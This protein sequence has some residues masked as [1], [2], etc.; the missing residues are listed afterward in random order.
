MGAVG[1][2]LDTK[3]RVAR[4]RPEEVSRLAPGERVLLQKIIHEVQPHRGVRPGTGQSTAEHAADMKKVFRE[5]PGAGEDRTGGRIEALV[6]GHVDGIVQLRVTSRRSTG[7][8]GF[9]EQAG[10]VKVQPD[11]LLTGIRCYAL[12]F[13]VTENG[14]VH[15]PYRRL[16]TDDAD[17]RLDAPGTAAPHCVL[18]LFQRKADPPRRQ[19][20]EIQTAQL[21]R[22]VAGIVVDVAFG[23]HDDTALLSRQ[24]PQGDVVRQRAGRHEHGALR[25][26]PAGKSALQF[27]NDAAI[28]I[29][30]GLQRPGCRYV[31]EKMGVFQ[32]AE[33][34]TVVDEVD[35][36]P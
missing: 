26:Q 24:L 17:V 13:F 29:C 12:H 11:P 21:L 4:Q 25:A 32:W 31:T 1:N 3:R 34:R 9:H 10:A 6:Q 36:L 27:L 20:K 5:G 7:M 22:A 2:R 18:H 35:G 16:D 28:G 30:V 19:R 14:I 23:L 8:G 15:A 33:V